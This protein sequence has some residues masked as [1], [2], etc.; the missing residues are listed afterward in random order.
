VQVKIM[1]RQ[2]HAVVVVPREAV[3][4]DNG[5]RYVFVLDGDKVRRRNITVGIASASNYEVVTGLNPLERVALPG[6][7]ALRDGMEV[8]P[9]EAN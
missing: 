1:V 6:E 4:E 9:T 3:R 7:R 2:R 5:Q 8:R